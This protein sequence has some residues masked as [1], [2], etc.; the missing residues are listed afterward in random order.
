[1][2]APLRAAILTSDRGG[3]L[4]ELAGCAYRASS[5]AIWLI[6]ADLIGSC[7]R[8]NAY[9]RPLGGSALGYELLAC[10][11]SDEELDAIADLWPPEGALDAGGPVEAARAARRAG[12]ER[13][14]AGA[15]R[16]EACRLAAV[17]RYWGAP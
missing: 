2:R 4:P 17:R 13:N 14:A 6:W 8:R 12:V 3:F 10:G 1:V 7:M 15:G 9:G 16:R 11:L 5:G